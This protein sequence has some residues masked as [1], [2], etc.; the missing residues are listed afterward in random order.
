MFEEEELADL[1]ESSGSEIADLPAAIWSIHR[2]GLNQEQGGVIRF[3]EYIEDLHGG[4]TAR[5][6]RR[7]PSTQ[8]GK[9]KRPANN[10][11]N[12]KG[13]FRGS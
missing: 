2:A 3:A 7:A 6:G 13:K 1:E 10:K 4:V 9:N 5:R 8:T 11:S 12:K